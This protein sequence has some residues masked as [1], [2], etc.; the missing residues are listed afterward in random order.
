MNKTNCIPSST[1]SRRL[2]NYGSHV[3]EL[4]A[5]PTRQ[6]E[7]SKAGFPTTSRYIKGLLND[8]SSSPQVPIDLFS[9][10]KGW[11]WV[12]SVSVGIPKL[13]IPG[14]ANYRHHLQRACTALALQSDCPAI[15][16]G[17]LLSFV[18]GRVTPSESNR[19]PVD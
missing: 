16:L 7:Q 11:V 12:Q 18:Q 2:Q 3:S 10:S 1:W 15:A 8:V 19:D 13:R 9:R 17:A 6:P 14:D 5:P 4:Q